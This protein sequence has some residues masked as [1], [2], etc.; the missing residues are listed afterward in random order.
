[1]LPALGTAAVVA[2]RNATSSARPAA[3]HPE[4]GGTCGYGRARLGGFCWYL[5]GWGLATGKTASCAAMTLTVVAYAAPGVGR[6]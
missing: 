4:S 5:G 6:P 2:F 1:M 3:R